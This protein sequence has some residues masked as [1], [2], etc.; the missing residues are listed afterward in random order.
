[1]TTLTVQD[2]SK[3]F[4]GVRA[5]D[6][7]SLT[8]ESGTVHGLVGPNGAGKS[9]A[10]GLISG[11]I[12]PDRGS[13]LLDDKEITRVPPHQLVRLGVVRTFQVPTA[14]RELTVLENVEAG[15][16][17]QGKAGTIRAVVRTPGMRK[18]EKSLRESA[19]E[20]LREIGLDPVANV[21]AEALPFGQL[22]FLEVVR[23]LATDPK[24]IMLDEPAAG[25]GRGE[26]DKLS[27]TI[28]KMRSDGRGVLLV[29]HDM[30]FMFALCDIITVMDAGRV[31]ARGTPEEIEH[32][33]IVREAYLGAQDTQEVAASAAPS[34][35]GGTDK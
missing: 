12:P 21:P 17:T 29:D 10:L 28:R 9:T 14:I 18:E 23:A 34:T 26:L 3:A 20:L 15:L 5:V 4:G 11:F 35:E 27:A 1:M 25:M 30:R 24:I 6:G 32:S 22:R 33:E 7:V 2:I 16:H 13:I 8:V 19:M 31:I